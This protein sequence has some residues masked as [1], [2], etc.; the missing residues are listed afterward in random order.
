MSRAMR[1]TSR[2]VT[3]ELG[4]ILCACVDVLRVDYMK[5]GKETMNDE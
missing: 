3:V 5:L 4:I 2:M 1:T